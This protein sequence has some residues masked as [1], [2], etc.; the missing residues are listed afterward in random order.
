[1]VCCVQW[2]CRF[3]SL[4]VLSVAVLT[5]CNLL[6]TVRLL[7]S[8][9]DCPRPSLP[10]PPSQSLQQQPQPRETLCTPEFLP[11]PV[12]EISD[13]S[14]Q[15]QLNLHLGRWDSRRLYRF[16]DWAVVGSRYVQL[17]EH[18]S[19]C[20]ATQSSLDRLFSLVQVAHQWAGP[21]SASIF[22]SSPDELKIIKLYMKFLIRCYSPVRERVSFHIAIPKDYPSFTAESGLSAG[23][24]SERLECIK[25]EASLRML[26]RHRRPEAMRWRVKLPYPQNHM[27]NLA[28][29]NCQTPHVFVTDVDVV[30][31]SKLAE[32]LDLFLRTQRCVEQCAYVIP[33]YEL[34]ERVRFPQNK[35]ELVRLAK[36]GLARP[37]HHKVFIYNQFATNFSRWQS[38]PE[39]AGEAV[40]ISHNVTN[41]E[42]LYEPFYVAPDT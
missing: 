15:L 18:Y 38:E 27:R 35:S 4:S 26:L 25:P 28:R 14:S 8:S 42:F 11:T 32:G 23:L 2:G 19:V 39:V 1:M 7:H 29:R 13:N 16:F 21:I 17:S 5:A 41:F 20:L 10:E 37:F 34:D 3:W 22:I 12:Q 24:E 30:P 9:S 40:H 33:T 6:L 36:K 31:S